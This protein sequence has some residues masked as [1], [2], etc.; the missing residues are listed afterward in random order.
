MNLQECEVLLTAAIERGVCK[1]SADAA[2]RYLDAGDVEGF[3]RVCRGNY[4]WLQDMKIAYTLTDGPAERWYSNGQ[5]RGQSNYFG[6]QMHG[7]CTWWYFGGQALEQSNYVNGQLHGECTWW[8]DDGQMC[9]QLNYVN[10]KLHGECAWWYRNGQ[11]RKQANYA[12]GNLHGECTLWYPGGQVCE[13]SNYVNGKLHGKYTRWDSDG[14]LIE[15]FN[16]VYGQR[17]GCTTRRQI[18]K[19]MNEASSFLLP[20]KINYTM[21]S[22]MTF[23]RKR[24]R[25]LMA[26][27]ILISWSFMLATIGAAVFL[28]TA[29]AA[30][31]IR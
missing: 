3:E 24:S 25:L 31:H 12:N 11:M 7:E 1:G 30:I 29:H 14:R 13:R 2:R 18:N 5:M 15:R 4:E 9:E 8:Y 10:G 16:Y 20:I 23:R 27:L 26:V 6:G 28:G 22:K 21:T 19:K 17:P